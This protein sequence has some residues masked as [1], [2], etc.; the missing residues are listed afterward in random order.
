M[1][2]GSQLS[3]FITSS[4]VRVDAF[5]V[6][7]LGVVRPGFEIGLACPGEGEVGIGSRGVSLQLFA[8]ICICMCVWNAVCLWF[9]NTRNEGLKHV[10]EIFPIS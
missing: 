2:H 7:G 3:L 9:S 5:Q 6:G 4:D 1:Q 10:D 8:V